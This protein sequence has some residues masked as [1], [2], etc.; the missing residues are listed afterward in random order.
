M[1]LLD[2]ILKFILNPLFIAAFISLIGITVYFFYKSPVPKNKSILYFSESDRV[3][4]ELKIKELT[5]NSLK[6]A[7]NKKFIRNSIAYTW[8]KGGKHIQTWIAKRGTAY[9]FKPSDTQK[10]KAQILGTLWNSL[11]GILGKDLVDQFSQEVKDLLRDSQVFVTVELEG[12][13]KPSSKHPN[14]DEK[15]VY[16]ESNQDMAALIGSRVKQQLSKEDWIRNVGLVACGVALTFLAHS[17]G[18]FSL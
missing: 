16:S 4:Q 9:T 18:L 13:T 3:L 11:E 2:T 5:I 14:L 17:L 6:T 8:D 15:D 1:A 12:G 7:D 10:G